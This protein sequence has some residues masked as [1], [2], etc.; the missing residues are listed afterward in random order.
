MKKRGEG[1]GISLQ[2][3]GG[4]FEE[5]QV[6]LRLANRQEEVGRGEKCSDTL[7]EVSRP[8]DSF[9]TK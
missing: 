2:Q 8:R 4:L 6:A 5:G 7:A 1:S 9:V 3:A